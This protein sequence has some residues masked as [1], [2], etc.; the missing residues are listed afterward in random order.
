M[1]EDTAKR[2][3]TGMFTYR[4]TD[5]GNFVFYLVASNHETLAH[6]GEAYKY[7]SSC[8]GG[9]ESVRNFSPIVFDG[10]IE[11]QTKEKVEKVTN[12]KW[13]VYKDKEGKFRFRLRA[14][15]GNLI[16]ISEAGYVSKQGCINGM[17]SV[18]NQSKDAP[19]IKLEK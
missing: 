17:K 9:I 12:P 5:N 6:G 1:A 4:K 14:N 19:V 10:K 13:E 11:D 8:I 15:N 7:E 2:G 3:Q 16:A 18:A